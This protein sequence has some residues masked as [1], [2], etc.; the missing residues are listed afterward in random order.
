MVQIE[1]EYGSYGDDLQYMVRLKQV[2]IYSTWCDSNRYIFTVHGATQTGIYL[3]YMVRL[4]QVSLQYSV[5]QK[6]LTPRHFPE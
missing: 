4:K 6:Y 3:Q 5:S 1:N 2:Y